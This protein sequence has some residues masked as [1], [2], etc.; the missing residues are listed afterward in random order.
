MQQ[1]VGDM[2]SD[3]AKIQRQGTRQGVTSCLGAM[4]FTCSTPP[5]STG[6]VSLLTPSLRTSL[7]V[8]HCKVQETHVAA[9]PKG[10]CCCSTTVH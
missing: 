3:W 8:K 5:I 6:R 4:P 7:S 9:G 10:C 2:H 1:G